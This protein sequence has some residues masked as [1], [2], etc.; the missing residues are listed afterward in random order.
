L[1]INTETHRQSK[2]EKDNERGWEGEEEIRAGEGEGGEE[3]ETV[4]A[5]EDGLEVGLKEGLEGLEVG[6]GAGV[7]R[8]QWPGP[9]GLQSTLRIGK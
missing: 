5:L 6:V 8:T 2:R 9:V 4:V 7:G 1:K 3:G